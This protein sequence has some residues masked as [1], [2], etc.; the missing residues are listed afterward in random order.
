MARTLRD[1]LAAARSVPPPPIR[2]LG[3]IDHVAIKLPDVDALASELAPL[4]LRLESVADH[5]EV[6][7]RVAFVEGAEVALELLG[8]ISDESPLAGD[9]D[10]LH[11]IA[12]RVEGVRALYDRL[13]RDERFHFIGGVRTGAR[14][15]EVVAFRLRGASA[16]AFELVERSAT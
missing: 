16:V 7:L 11:H 15:H 1:M 5:P 13:R 4:G 8:V 12:Y 14:G 6:G 3:G 2:G 10:G 9:G